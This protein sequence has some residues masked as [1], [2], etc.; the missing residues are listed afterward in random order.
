MDMESDLCSV[1]LSASTRSRNDER[2]NLSQLLD[3]V[4]VII[5]EYLDPLD[6]NYCE[7]VCHR[8]RNILSRNIIWSKLHSRKVKHSFR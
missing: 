8:W 7:L 2:S 4:L 6:L 3:E 5:F 1:A